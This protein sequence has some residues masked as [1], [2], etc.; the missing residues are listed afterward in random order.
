M[1]AVVKVGQ[2]W[3]RRDP[4]GDTWDQIEVIGRFQVT[5]DLYEWI[6]Q[7]VG[8]LESVAA[9]AESL[10]TSFRLVSNPDAESSST[11][12]EWWGD[13]LKS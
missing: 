4:Q 10:E 11:A 3:A 1:A 5:A 9:S 2:R 12:L 6:V 8:G 13:A 7:P